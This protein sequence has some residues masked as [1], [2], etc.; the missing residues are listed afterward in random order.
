MPP[1]LFQ[2]LLFPECCPCSV[3]FRS[4]PFASVGVLPW[5]SSL[6]CPVECHSSL[7]YPPFPL[8]TFPFV[9]VYTCLCIPCPLSWCFFFCGCKSHLCSLH[10]C[11]LQVFFFTVPDL[12]PLLHPPLPL[13]SWTDVSHTCVVYKCVIYT[14]KCS[15]LSALSLSSVPDLYLLLHYPSL[16][17]TNVSSVSVLHST[18]TC[19]LSHFFSRTYTVDG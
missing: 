11:D 5:P 17:A 16:L 3:P 9:G 7:P 1:L 19:L 2:L 12:Y 18:C 14:Y 13:S 10:K 15:L 4:Q 6:P 8:T